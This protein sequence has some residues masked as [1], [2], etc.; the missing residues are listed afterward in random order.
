VRVFEE[1][2]K[3]TQRERG[4]KERKDDGEGDEGER[5]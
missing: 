4:T 5:E 2:E 1:R 3:E